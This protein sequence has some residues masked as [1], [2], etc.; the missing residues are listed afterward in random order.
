MEPF[1]LLSFLCFVFC[2]VFVS[3]KGKL[4]NVIIIS[5]EESTKIVA[6]NSSFVLFWLSSPKRQATINSDSTSFFQTVGRF[7]LVVAMTVISVVIDPVYIAG[8]R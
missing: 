1:A 5:K 2:F 4:I 6:G 7:L 3:H 8:V